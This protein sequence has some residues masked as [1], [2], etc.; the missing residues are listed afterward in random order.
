MPIVYILINQS[1]NQCLILLKFSYKYFN[2]GNENNNNT[3]KFITGYIAEDLEICNNI[4]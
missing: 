2:D 4:K 1:I 3:K